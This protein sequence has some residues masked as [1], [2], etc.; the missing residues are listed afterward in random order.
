MTTHKEG[1]REMQRRAAEACM[2]VVDP[3]PSCSMED[4]AW[5]TACISCHDAIRRLPLTEAEPAEQNGDWPEDFAHE[6]GGYECRCVDCGKMFCGHKSRVVCKTCAKPAEPAPEPVTTRLSDGYPIAR[7][8]HDTYERLAPQFGYETRADTK[9]FDPTTP[10]GKLMVAVC[11]EM[12]R[13]IRATDALYA[14]PAEDARDAAIGRWM[15]KNCAWHRGD[16]QGDSIVV[17]VA[18]GSD[19]SCVA[20]RRL[21]VEAA[22]KGAAK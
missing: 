21:A 22:M 18:K 15:L 8:F 17:Y 9:Q 7:A 20:T 6:N 11:A 14:A 3:K 16:E 13:L 5:N 1:Q 2:G 4:V 10:N 12:L 19:L